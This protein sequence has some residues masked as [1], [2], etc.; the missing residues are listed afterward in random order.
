MR[1]YKTYCVEDLPFPRHLVCCHLR[2]VCIEGVYYCVVCGE[3][4]E[5]DEGSLE[6]RSD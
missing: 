5:V 2:V 1:Y 4:V 6:A 3:R